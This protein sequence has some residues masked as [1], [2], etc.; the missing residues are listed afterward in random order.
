MEELNTR[1]NN[2]KEIEVKVDIGVWNPLGPDLK[3]GLNAKVG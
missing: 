3:F 1:N 2:I